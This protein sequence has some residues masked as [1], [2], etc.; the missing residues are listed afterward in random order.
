[1]NEVRRRQVGELT[2]N[3]GVLAWR[4]GKGLSFDRIA[5]MGARIGFTHSFRGCAVGLYWQVELERDDECCD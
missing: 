5:H 1:M 3:T 2:V 4:G